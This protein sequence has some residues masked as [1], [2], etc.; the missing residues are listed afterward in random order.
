MACALPSPGSTGRS[1]HQIDPKAAPHDALRVAAR[2]TTE[3]PNV[4]AVL[5]ALRSDVREMAHEQIEYRDLLLT[6]VRRDLLLRYKQT[7]M[8]FG[9]AVF[10]PVLNTVIFSVIFMRVAPLE[11]GLPYPLFAFAG[12]LPW[13]FLASSLRFSVVSLTSNAPLVTK[14]YFPR[15]IFP[16]SA[17]IVSLVDFLV[18]STVLAALMI[19][20]RVELTAAVL[21]MP[22]VL[23][24]QIAFTA[25]C[26]MLLAMANLFYRDVKYLFEILLTLWMFATAVVY[27][28]DRVGGRLGW[29]LSLNPMTPII[30]AY[31]DV[32]L[33]GTLPAAGPFAYAAAAS[34][35]VL[36]GGWLVFHRAEFKF[37][38]SI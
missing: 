33:R 13:N 20:Y 4:N 2:D 17:V 25:G 29:L 28:I 18:A 37:A 38:E 24:V 22:V 21:F 1:R 19:Y 12:L 35:V 34:L 31:R 23:V 16:F 10:M 3:P 36:L 30:E 14:V 5:S 32:L 26:A 27:P 6:I 9:W 15:E 11:T 8:G 7:V